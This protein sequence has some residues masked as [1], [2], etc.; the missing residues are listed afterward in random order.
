[1]ETLNTPL[2]SDEL[3]KID[4][5]IHDNI[6]EL[7]ALSFEVYENIYLFKPKVANFDQYLGKLNENE[8]TRAW[9]YLFTTCKKE[10]H[11]YLMAKKK[12]KHNTEASPIYLDTSTIKY[13]STDRRLNF[14]LIFIG[15]MGFVL[16]AYLLFSSI[17][18]SKT[19]VMSGE[20]STMDN[21]LNAIEQKTGKRLEIVIDK[22]GN[23]SGYLGNTKL[24]FQCETES[25]GTKGIIVKG[26]YEAE[27]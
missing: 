7:S 17:G 20:F 22:V 27:D 14:V 13:N 15:V 8:K 5:F 23:I 9:F 21:C 19:K 4:E 26:W 18:N 2:N 16:I 6:N 10:R 12:E 24:D 25:T 11:K 1:M 3:A